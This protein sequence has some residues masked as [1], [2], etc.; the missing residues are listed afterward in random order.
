[1]KYNKIDLKAIIIKQSEVKAGLKT[2]TRLK[3]TRQNKNK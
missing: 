3:K 1:M 2:R